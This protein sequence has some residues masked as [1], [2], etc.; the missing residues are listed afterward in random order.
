MYLVYL[1]DSAVDQNLAIKEA[2]IQLWKEKIRFK[3]RT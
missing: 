3:M 2:E 1:R